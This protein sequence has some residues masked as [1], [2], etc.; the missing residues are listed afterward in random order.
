MGATVKFCNSSSLTFITK[1]RE[2]DRNSNNTREHME[3]SR[4]NIVLQGVNVED[5]A[6]ICAPHFEVFHQKEETKRSRGNFE[7][8]AWKSVKQRQH[9]TS[10]PVH[11]RAQ[12]MG[13]GVP[14]FI[15]GCQRKFVIK[16]DQPS[17]FA[18]QRRSLHEAPMTQPKAG[19]QMAA[20]FSPTASPKPSTSVLH[21][22]TV[23]ICLKFPP[24]DTRVFMGN[25]RNGFV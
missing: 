16:F 4:L 8:P 10:G 23:N 1:P 5:G 20:I 12:R 24:T 21:P 25:D 17:F 14:T 18:A 15:C 11:F 19:S 3:T 9:V 13:G 22:R 6:R 7:K 2:T